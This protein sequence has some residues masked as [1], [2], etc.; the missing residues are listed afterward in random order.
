MV[1]RLG[2]I[3]ALEG[4]MNTS[5]RYY[6]PL[7]EA[8]C[9]FVR[10]AQTS[11]EPPAETSAEPADTAWLRRPGFAKVEP[12][13][14]LAMR[15]LLNARD[16]ASDIQ[17]ALTVIGRRAAGEGRLDLGG[18]RIPGA[19]LIEA[20]LVGAFL[21]FAD[22]SGAD[23]PSAVLTQEQLDQA[24][25]TGVKGLDKLDPPLTFHDKPC[26]EKQQ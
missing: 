5:E 4:V 23:L 7:L 1:A 13:T 10:G 6:R 26:P 25:G 19:S 15:R 17:A 14:R 20:N 2:G 12:P 11:A 22:L 8:L 24:C 3:Y 18:V 9:A 16:P 21:S